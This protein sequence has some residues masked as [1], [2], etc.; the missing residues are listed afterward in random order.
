MARAVARIKVVARIKAVESIR[1]L[2]AGRRIN[3]VVRVRALAGGASRRV[4]VKAAAGAVRAAVVGS[5]LR[6]AG[7]RNKFPRGRGAT[8]PTGGSLLVFMRLYLIGASNLLRSTDSWLSESSEGLGAK[9][10]V[11]RN[12]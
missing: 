6:T 2:R 5:Q 7:E 8:C 10:F 4:E 11:D 12:S 1:R 3:R 9:R